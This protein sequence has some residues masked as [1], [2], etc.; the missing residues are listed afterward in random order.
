MIKKL[1]YMVIYIL[2]FSLMFISPV[3]AKTQKAG[4]KYNGYEYAFKP[5]EEKIFLQNADKNMQLFEKAKTNTDKI[6]YL[7]EAMRYY[8]LLEQADK[9]SIE[10][11][12]GLG[13]VYD[14][15]KF[16]RFAKEHF[17][18]A[19]NFDNND[20]KMNLYFANFYYK[21]NDFIMALRYYNRA[22]KYGYS[23][24]YYLNYRIGQAYEK[25]ADI[26]N[27]KKF[28]KSASIL[29]PQN[30]ELNNKIRLLDELNYAQS[31]YYLFHK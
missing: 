8:F 3:L 16:D 2:I 30:V 7:K 21:R 11:Q 9:S 20:P 1:T 31:Q 23:K 24:N 27:A 15:M 18:N 26:E 17:F 12:I 22:Y 5:G 4:V 28:Y 13:R 29:N 25:L 10:A 19:Y 6:F 14:E